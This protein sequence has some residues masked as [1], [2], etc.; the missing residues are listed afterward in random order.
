MGFS[1]KALA[2]H[3]WGSSPSIP[4]VPEHIQDQL[5]SVTRHGPKMRKNFKSLTLHPRP[6]EMTLE[7]SITGQGN[8]EPR[9]LLSLLPYVGS[10][11]RL[12]ALTLPKHSWK[13]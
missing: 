5:S 8:E 6:Q 12:N 10:R 9:K 4:I 13:E 11:A 3:M 7:L 2:L 1:G